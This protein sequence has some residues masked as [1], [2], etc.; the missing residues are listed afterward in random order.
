MPRGRVRRVQDPV[1]G[2]MEFR[3]MESIV[4]EVLRAPE[5]QRLRR[6]RQLGLA[7]LVFPGA[8][9]SRLVHS[10]GASYLAIQ[11]ARRLQEACHNYLV[12]AL[13][14]SEAAV[15]D[16]ALA[17]L[18]HDLGHGPLSHAWEREVVGED[19]P[20]ERWLGALG[21]VSE[22]E[23]LAG[24]KWH[25]VVAQGLLAWPGGQL[26]QLRERHEAGSSQRLRFLL[27]GKHYIPYL[28]R[29][30]R[31][32]VDVDRAD[33]IRRDTHQCGVAYGRYDLDWLLSTCTVGRT[34]EDELVVG[35]DRRKALRV[36]EQFLVA[37]RALY[38]TVYYH[39]TVHSAEGMVTL[40]LRRLREVIRDYTPLDAGR[41][42]EPLVR[43]ISG[44]VLEPP[45]LLAL[46]DFSL[47]VLIDNVAHAPRMDATARDLAR[48]VVER[49]LF[50]LVPCV[51]RRVNEFLRRED[52]Y[53]RLYDAIRPY[54][55]GPPQFYLWVDV[56][57]FTMLSDR[58]EE[59]AYFVGEDRIATPVREHESI[60]PL[61]REDDESVRL[62]TVP[63]AVER[64][65][66]LIG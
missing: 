21:L 52:G 36:V 29:L 59:W 48:R 16:A 37:R 65:A 58:R 27:Q 7:H 45:E 12:E 3:G 2:L 64:V 62:F 40:F 17:A 23:R 19:Y 56:S 25:E 24:L 44:E 22:Q 20:R 28:P 4:I 14:P 11:F 5:L 42:V 63:E 50:K 41:V 60:R 47:W 10:L 54:C 6:V 1:H 55:P 53:D 61:W 46:D 15:R 38:E 43:V 57:R 26:H 33:F 9:H 39:K 13:T 35:F 32:D 18:C 34:A 30:L 66:A 8:E 31:A 49:D 51:D